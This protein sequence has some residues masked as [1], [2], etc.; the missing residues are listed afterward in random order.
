V[1]SDTHRVELVNGGVSEALAPYRQMLDRTMP[2]AKETPSWTRDMVL[3]EVL[4][5]YFPDGIRGVTKKL[6]FCKDVGFNTVS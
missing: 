2:V 1:V 4:P 3:L 6:P 5:S